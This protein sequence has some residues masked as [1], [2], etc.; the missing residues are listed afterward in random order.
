MTYVALLR[1]INVG[2]SNKVNMKELKVAFEEAGMAAVRTYIN[3]GNVVFQTNLRSQARLGKALEEAIAERFGLAIRVA[4]RDVNTM[5]KLVGSMP[6]E[7][8]DDQTMR[9]YVM[10]LLPEADN[11][12]V[13]RQLTF[14]PDIE[15]VFYVS[16]AVV[17]R[18]DRKNLT[19]SGMM[20]LTASPLY[21]QMTIRNCNTVRK[22]LQL[23]E[24]GP[25]PPG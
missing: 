23:M 14:K 12:S 15:D 4:L 20:K 11:P 3:S 8:R 7:W 13:V 1:G 18:V 16:G 19:K 17:W 10:F 24:S 2:G 5:R 9:C 22:L 6:A 25:R 21:K